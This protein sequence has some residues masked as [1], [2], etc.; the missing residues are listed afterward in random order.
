MRIVFL[1]ADV[2]KKKNK[3]IFH[4]NP[5]IYTLAACLSRNLLCKANPKGLTGEGTYEEQQLT[6]GF[7]PVSITHF[8]IFCFSFFSLCETTYIVRIKS[9]HMLKVNKTVHSNQT[10]LSSFYL[11]NPKPDKTLI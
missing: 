11:G 2:T 10:S 5:C 3:A 1:D 6:F 4:L 8:F 9:F 7:K